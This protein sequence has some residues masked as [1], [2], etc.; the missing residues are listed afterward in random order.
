MSKQGKVHSLNVIFVVFVFLL[1]LSNLGYSVEI[2]VPED[3]PTITQALVM[4]T[5]G[6]TIKVAAKTYSEPNEKFPLRL[7]KAVTLA[8]ISDDSNEHNSKPHLRGDGKHTV[9][10]I[11]SG[12]ATLQGFIIT[13]GLGSEGINSMDGGGV[14]VFVGPSE[15]NSVTIRDCVIEDNIC[16]SDETYDGCGGGIYC[17]GTYCTCFKVKISN[18]I[19]RRNSVHGTGG[20]ISCALLS[21]V[22]INDTYIED[23][24][25]DDKG[26][27]VYVD[28]FAALDM[29]NTDLVW[30]NCPGDPNKED[31]GGKGGGLSC[32]SYGFFTATNCTFSQN[33][34][35]YF[36]GGI[37]TRG[38]FFTGEDL[39]GGSKEFP[40]VSCSLIEKNSAGLSGGGAYIAGSAVLDFSETTLYRNDVNHAN[41]DGGAVYVAGGPT[42]G[43]VVHFADVCLLE[44]NECGGRGGGIY[45]GPY[46]FGIFESTRFLGNS[47]LLDGGGLFLDTDASC[48]LMDCCIT[49]NNSARSHAG[50]IRAK[51]QSWLDLDHCSLVGNFAPYGRSGLYLDPNTI[52]YITDSILWH[53]AGGSV[54][55]N[56]ATIN[57]NTSLSEDGADPNNGV[58]CCDPGY[59]G[60]GDI[61]EI[62]VGGSM[63]GPGTGTLASPY[64]DLQIALDSFNFQL[65]ANSPCVNT[66]SGG[67]NM[68]ADTGVGGSAGNVIAKLHLMDGT[69]DIR[70]RNISFIQEVRGFVR[71]MSVIQH[72]VFGGIDDV[73][74][75]AVEITGEEIFGGIVSR[76]DVNFVDSDVSSNTALANGG[77]IYVADGNCVLTNSYVSQNT[78]SSNGGGLYSDVN[79]VTII[80]DKSWI[81][82]NS[83]VA[84]GGIHA[85][86]R[87]RV[88]D[89]NFVRNSANIGG[90]IN[91]GQLGNL[92]VISSHFLTNNAGAQGGAINSHGKLEIHDSLFEFNTAHA[93]GAIHIWEEPVGP[94][95]CVNGTFRNNTAQQGGAFNLANF[96]STVFRDC[97]F[98]ENESLGWGGGAGVC[99]HLSNPIFSDCIFDGNKSRRR[100][101]SVSLY[102]SGSRFSGCTFSRSFSN[103]NGGAVYVCRSNALLFE[104]CDIIDSMCNGNGGAF[105]ITDASVPVLSNVHIVNCQAVSHGGAIA[106]YG[107]ARPKLAEVYISDCNAV[108]GGGLYACGTSLSLF[109]GCRFLDNSTYDPT[110]PPDGGGAYFTENAGG[111]F[112]R[113][114]FQGNYAQDDGGGMGV[115]EQATVGLWNT[116]FANNVAID[117]GGG[118]HFT[119]KSSGTFT[120]CTLTE[121]MSNG[122]TGAGIY[123]EADSTVSADSSLIC[124]NVPDGIRTDAE[125]NVCYSCTQK[126]WPGPGN[127]LCDDCC[128]LDPNSFELTDG[129][130]CIDMGNPDP[131]M[132]DAHRPPGKGE[133]RNDVGITGGPYNCADVCYDQFNFLTFNESIPLILRGHA[134]FID[135]VLGLTKAKVWRVGGAWYA[136][137]VNVLNG[138][139]TVF[140]FRIDRDGSD[141]FAFVIQNDN[142]S[143]LGN[144]GVY[145]GY[146]I[147]NSIAIEFDTWKNTELGDLSHNHISVQTHGTEIN[148]PQSDYT[149]GYSDIPFFSDNL[150]HF[151]RISYVPHHLSVFMGDSLGQMDEPVLS[152]SLDLESIMSL[153]NGKAFIGFTAGTGGR[154][155][156]HDILQWSFVSTGTP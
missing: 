41:A 56:G 8:G 34:A 51:S 86:G 15:T 122:G 37:F 112:T 123:L 7:Q 2:R 102:N 137:P 92:S 143:S 24:T 62:Y 82:D 68:G 3:Y 53:N 101:G 49:Y 152:I 79:T 110:R 13:D 17:G 150:V 95:L 11:E 65:A 104:D 6:D 80:A 109:Q 55:T 119:W 139:E 117:D 84:G 77:G 31:W 97:V 85:S 39:C 14:C 129:S 52:V 9:V 141:G 148:G 124:R 99:W 58:L 22:D 50:G 75:T 87:L 5:D 60:W 144:Y 54:E 30:N 105:F 35:K 132:N 25:A 59:I 63:P 71:A 19:I 43:G 4:A 29:N 28:V 151:V 26:G 76:E 48:E 125:P 40:Y 114:R 133:L 45:L 136:F 118:V 156:T 38:G 108:Y 1:V 57:I 116:L 130:P 91:I 107:R 154:G 18:C 127:G 106:V 149:L 32:E 96:M 67:S 64:A 134:S 111:L 81:S 115:A 103:E 10:L 98:V 93:G 138:F 83:S 36:G 46:A 74:I 121:N 72:A 147:P 146:N 145:M 135:G 120:N 131:N 27:G 23:N 90:A 42:G 140:S 89:S 94:G 142:L 155:E 113:C 100:G 153:T 20:G 33:S 44:G 78:S 126:M 66:A 69:Y 70:G 16:P 21:N 128:M 73:S 47:A 88:T 12:G 61:E